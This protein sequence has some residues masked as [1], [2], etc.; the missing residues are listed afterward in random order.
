MSKLLGPFALF[1]LPP[2]QCFNIVWGG[3]G[4]EG[5]KKGSE[6]RTHVAHITMEAFT[7]NSLLVAQNL[8][9]VPKCFDPDCSSL[10][11]FSRRRYI[12]RDLK[13]E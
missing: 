6:R 5:R 1:P 13:R 2:L 8:T 9:S 4:E 10:T 7:G 3:G 12:C 11:Q